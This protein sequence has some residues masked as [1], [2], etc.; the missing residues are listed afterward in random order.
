MMPMVHS[1]DWQQMDLM[2]EL[3][4]VNKEKDK[5]ACQLRQRHSY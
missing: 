3:A 2:D 1:F 4:E 5:N